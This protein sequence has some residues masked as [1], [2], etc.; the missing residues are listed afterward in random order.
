MII[1]K[2]ARCA[3]KDTSGILRMV[4]FCAKSTSERTLIMAS[5]KS[6]AEKVRE[7]LQ[8][9]DAAMAKRNEKVKELILELQLQKKRVAVLEDLAEF[10]RDRIAALEDR[11]ASISLELKT[12]E[13]ELLNI[14]DLQSENDVGGKKLKKTGTSK[15]ASKTKDLSKKRKSSKKKA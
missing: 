11:N 5:R 14:K 6:E 12:K 2:S 13:V 4:D 7:L 15:K 10:H 3:L 1:G 8:A 9:G